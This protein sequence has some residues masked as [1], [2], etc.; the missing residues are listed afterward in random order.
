MN[1]TQAFLGDP[2]EWTDVRVELRDVHGLWGGRNCYVWGSG[3]VVVQW[4]PVPQHEERYAFTV[5]LA[6]VVHLL[7][8]AIE[9][10]LVTVTFPPRPITPDEACPVITLINAAG[11]VRRVH[12]WANDAHPGFERVYQLLLGLAERARQGDR[13]YQGPFDPNFLPA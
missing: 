10:D 1:A 11:E 4:L 5:P 9:A 7:V 6:E 2:E 8:A 13:L 12:K 3:R